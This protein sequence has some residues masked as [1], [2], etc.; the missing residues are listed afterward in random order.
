M[1]ITEKPEETPQRLA[2]YEKIASLS[3]TS[4]AASTPW[5]TPSAL[6]PGSW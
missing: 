4:I 2:F 3:Y 1:S 6:E 5:A